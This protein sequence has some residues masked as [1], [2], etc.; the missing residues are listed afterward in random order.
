MTVKLTQPLPAFRIDDTVLERLWRMLEAKCA[1]VGP[2]QGSLSVSEKVRVADRRTPEEHDHKYGSVGEL[3]RTPGGLA[4]LRDYRL[5]FST[6]W[7]R[8]GRYV[9]FSAA[10]GSAASVGMEAPDAAWCRK[11]ADA[12]LEVLRPHTV[13]YG[14]LHRVSYGTIAAVTAAS[15]TAM[16]AL[17][18]SRLATVVE[19]SPCSRPYCALMGLMSCWRERFLPAADIRVRRRGA[20][21]APPGGGQGS[22]DHPRGRGPGATGKPG[23][24]GSAAA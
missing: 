4:L 14:M 15:V 16:L 12:V 10:G 21:P 5:Y 20:Q 3:R 18:G 1:E 17:I 23:A 6:P 11:V 24:H 7:G 8:D 9:S 19:T 2:P 22:G 13:R